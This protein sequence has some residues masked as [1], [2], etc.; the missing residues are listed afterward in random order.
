MWTGGDVDSEAT[1]QFK[2]IWVDTGH[3]ETWQTGCSRAL[4]NVI[5]RGIEGSQIFGSDFEW[6]DLAQRRWDIPEQKLRGLER[7]RHQRLT[8]RRI[9][10]RCLLYSGI[11]NLLGNQRPVVQCMLL[12]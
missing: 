6:A 1:W 9:Q 10:R 3:S 2:K 7:S 8:R 12:K 4:H 5:G 11:C